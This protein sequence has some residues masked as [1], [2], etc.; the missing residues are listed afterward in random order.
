MAEMCALF[1]KPNGKAFEELAKSSDFHPRILI[2]L[3]NSRS[4]PRSA[5]SFTS[6]ILP[7]SSSFYFIQSF[8]FSSRITTGTGILKQQA[9]TD[10]SKKKTG[11]EKELIGCVHCLPEREDRN[12]STSM[13]VCHRF[14]IAVIFI[15]Y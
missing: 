2:P 12:N 10:M 15:I 1:G 7:P 11:M 4:K 13:L 8:V 6:K 3:G 5:T 9:V 14:E